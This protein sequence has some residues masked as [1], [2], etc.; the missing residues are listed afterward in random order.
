MQAQ[1]LD[2]MTFEGPF[3][4]CLILRFCD[5][6]KL[7]ILAVGLG[8]SKQRNHPALAHSRSQ[9]SFVPA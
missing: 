9:S 1:E 7:G 5:S 8:A 4:L 6:A 2:S 3:H